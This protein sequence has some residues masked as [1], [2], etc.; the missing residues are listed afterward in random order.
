MSKVEPTSTSD[1]IDAAQ[2][3]RVAAKNIETVNDDESLNRWV[4][5]AARAS[6]RLAEAGDSRFNILANI[7]PAD[8]KP[9]MVVNGEPVY[10]PLTQKYHH[11][12][13]GW[14]GFDLAVM[15]LIMMAR[16]TF[17]DR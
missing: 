9:D 4:A 15:E 11:Q 8:A 7:R 13:A 12:R 1:R 2:Q 3:L 10:R 5:H 6:F 16:E 14:S 17:P